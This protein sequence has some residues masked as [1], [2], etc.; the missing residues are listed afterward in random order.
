MARTISGSEGVAANATVQQLAAVNTSTFNPVA[1]TSRVSVYATATA[2]GSFLRL[3]L[4]AD[5]HA[6]DI[7]LQSAT[8]STRDNLVATGVALRGQKIT[9]G[10]RNS[11]GALI[12]VNYYVVIEPLGGA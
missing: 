3:T 7:A 10:A 11:T 4:G 1:V 12:T 5:V 2:T 9:V 8:L 6:E